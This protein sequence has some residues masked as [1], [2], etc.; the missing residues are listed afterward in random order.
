MTSPVASSGSHSS[1]KDVGI[2]RSSMSSSIG[3]A[4]CHASRNTRGAAS[5]T[6]PRM[7]A[8]SARRAPPTSAS[9]TRLAPAGPSARATPRR[10]PPSAPRA[11]PA[12]PC[13][14]RSEPAMASSGA[15]RTARSP[16][17]APVLAS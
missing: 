16:P 17:A 14:R 3:S 2:K 11:T 10:Q 7:I 12:A 6:K 1:V 5:G 15:Y 4:R 8:A 13:A 9:A